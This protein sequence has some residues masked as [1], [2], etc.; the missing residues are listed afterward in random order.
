[1]WCDEPCHF[2]WHDKWYVIRHVHDYYLSGNYKCKELPITELIKWKRKGVDLVFRYSRWVEG[3]WSNKREEFLCVG[4]GGK[5][6]N[7]ELLTGVLQSITS[8]ITVCLKILYT[9]FLGSV[10]HQKSPWKLYLIHKKTFWTH[11]IFFFK[12]LKMA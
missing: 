1:M 9:P 10:Y 3:G 5:G 2:M 4:R 6:R 8:S 12:N 11:L 7:K